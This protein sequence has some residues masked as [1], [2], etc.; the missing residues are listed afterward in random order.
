MKTRYSIMAGL[1]AV[2]FILSAFLAS[3]HIGGTIK[4]K[5]TP[6]I[7]AFRAAA[8]SS[9]SDSAKVNIVAGMFEIKDLKPGTYNLVIEAAIPYKST[10]KTGVVVKEAET[11]D[12]GEILLTQ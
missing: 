1:L 10:I 7:G 3:T 2:A 5:V 8:F 12:V 11:T 9:S 4:G 6:A